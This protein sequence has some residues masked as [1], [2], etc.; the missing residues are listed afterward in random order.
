MFEP[1]DD[2]ND[3]CD[4]SNK[5]NERD[6]AT[7]DHLHCKCILDYSLLLVKK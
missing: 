6:D 4:D 1:F 2:E 7:G 3:D 5:N